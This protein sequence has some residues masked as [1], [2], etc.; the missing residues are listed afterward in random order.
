MLFKEHRQIMLKYM[1]NP[2]SPI[3][4]TLCL[5]EMDRYNMY[6]HLKG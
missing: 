3:P 6:V 5:K 1:V 2:Q 4:I